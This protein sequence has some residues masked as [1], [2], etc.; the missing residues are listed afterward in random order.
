MGLLLFEAVADPIPVGEGEIQVVRPAGVPGDDLRAEVP[1]PQRVLQRG[2]GALGQL[3][4]LRQPIDEAVPAVRAK[5]ERIPGEEV[6]SSIQTVFR[7]LK[8]SLPRNIRLMTR[9]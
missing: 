9:F 5:P 1:L 4:V 8:I 2:Q 6:C 7:G 3:D